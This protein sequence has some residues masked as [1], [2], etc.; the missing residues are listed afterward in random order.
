M[1]SRALLSALF[2]GLVTLPS[3]CN[4]YRSDVSKV[5]DA[6]QLAPGSLKGGRAAL[7][8]WMERNVASS[9]GIVLV[10]D[11]EGK[12]SRGIAIELHDEA[13]KVGVGAC[14]LA[15]QADMQTKDEDSHTDL[16]NL[17]QG[18][19]LRSDGS[20]AR[21]DIANASDDERLNEIVEWTR[22][23]AKSP[24]T[25][26]VID[27]IAKAGPRQRGGVLRAE[28]ARLNI[29]ACLMAG[30]LD[31]P[32]PA[33]T[34]AGAP[35]IYPSYTVLKVDAAA[36]SVFPI[37]RAMV[38]HEAAGALNTC[39]NTALLSGKPGKPAITGKVNMKLSFDVQGHI[40]KAADDGSQLRG[41]MMSCLEQA[42]TT[43]SAGAALTE[44]KKGGLKATVSLQFAP[45]TP[46]PGYT[47]E[48]E[49]AYQAKITPKKR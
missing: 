36:K 22:M 38:S 34:P 26:A 8:T 18:S 9:D 23:N 7:F 41:P 12:D 42:M 45:V 31:A 19:A 10:R 43:L 3:M 1:A 27:K 15:D 24:D 44:A 35:Q 28:A 6:E 13:R 25:A 47:A 46:G 33:A 29:T 2:G 17:C 16:A 30:T 5:C 49:P 48:I 20:I 11:I 21:L 32:P 4:V 14:A 40:V 39:Y 37:A